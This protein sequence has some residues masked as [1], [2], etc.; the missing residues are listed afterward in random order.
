MWD[1]S[2]AIKMVPAEK[3]HQWPREG[4]GRLL[5]GLLERHERR[6]PHVQCHE[7]TRVARVAYVALE[8]RR[9]QEVPGSF[10]VFENEHQVGS[11]G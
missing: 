1:P 8:V 4:S 11:G 7:G 2:E 6:C 3:L 9:K 5:L 10:W